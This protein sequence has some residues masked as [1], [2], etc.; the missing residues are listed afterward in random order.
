MASSRLLVHLE[1]IERDHRDVDSVDVELHRPS[2]T[3]IERGPFEAK[4]LQR[5]NDPLLRGRTHPDIEIDG[6]ARVPMQPY[7]VASDQKIVNAFS[8]RAILRI[9]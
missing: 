3:G 6:R 1:V 2:S 9:L 7:R 5:V 4:V 8:R